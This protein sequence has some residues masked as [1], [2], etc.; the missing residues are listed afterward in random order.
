[1]I[2]T[3]GY[4]EF[5]KYNNIYYIK[6]TQNKNIYIQMPYFFYLIKKKNHKNQM[7]IIHNMNRKRIPVK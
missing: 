4:F 2:T 6:K 5:Q 3:I 1:M 7:H